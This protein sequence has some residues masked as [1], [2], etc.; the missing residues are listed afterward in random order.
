MDFIPLP[1]DDTPT[2]EDFEEE[3][4]PPPPPPP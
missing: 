2:L 1:T 3:E 4:V